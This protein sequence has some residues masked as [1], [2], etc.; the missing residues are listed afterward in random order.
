MRALY[1][2]ICNSRTT[3]NGHGLICEDCGAEYDYNGVM[4]MSYDEQQDDT[5]DDEDE[6]TKNG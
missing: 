3:N 5:S 1:C 6:N 4:I 2:S